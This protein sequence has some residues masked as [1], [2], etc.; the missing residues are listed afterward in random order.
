MS[1]SGKKFQGRQLAKEHL[2][3]KSSI[4]IQARGT[5]MAD[6]FVDERG[7]DYAKRALWIAAA[8]SHNVLMLWT[9]CPS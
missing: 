9:D 4:V 6:D 3:P 5:Q 8:G 1:C 2:D 7:Q